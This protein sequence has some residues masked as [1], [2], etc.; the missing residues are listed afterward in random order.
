MILPFTKLETH[1]LGTTDPNGII[2]DNWPLIEAILI[3]S[4]FWFKS[5]T[6]DGKV[7]ATTTINNVSDTIDNPTGYNYV[8]D[9]MLFVPVN[10][11]GITTLPQIEI[12]EDVVGTN[13]LVTAMTP[14]ATATQIQ[15]LT[16]ANPRPM[17]LA[18]GS[19]KV[20]VDTV[21]TGTNGT[22]QIWAKV[23]AR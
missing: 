7:L 21:A 22:F 11:S 10:F 4:S 9:K 14:T 12:G 1:P 16:L 23:V 8:V 2:T 20:K 15:E 19:M 6:I 3:A 18:T 5:G 13:S 17:I